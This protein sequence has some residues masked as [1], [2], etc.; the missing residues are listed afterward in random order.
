MRIA[1]V[2]IVHKPLDIRIFQKEC[3][4]LAAAGHEVHLLISDPPS[5]EIDGVRF[6]AIPGLGGVNYFWRALRRLP[7]AYR[8]ARAVDASVYHLHDPHLIPLGLLLKRTGA[9]VV[10]DAH[11]D[12]PRQ[13]VSIYADRPLTGRAHAVVWSV[14]EW[15]AR[16]R[17]DAFVAA[18]PRILERF[19][20]ARSVV[21]HNF[22]LAEEFCHPS[23][24]GARLPQGEREH[25]VVYVGGI[26][27]VRCI[28]EMVDMLELVPAALGARLVLM[29]EFSKERPELEVEVRAKRGWERVEYLGYRSRGEVVEQLAKARIGLVLMYPLPNHVEAM[30]NKMWEY[31]AAGLP[32]IA[33]NFPYWEGILSRAGCGLVVDPKDPREI[34]EAVEH[35]LRYPDEAEAMGRRGREAYEQRYNWAPEGERLVGVYRDLAARLES[36]ARAS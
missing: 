19:P 11:E 4:T 33:S 14:L 21:V 35:L 15:L 10:Y 9:V 7:T 32:I 24:D 18:T 22:P 1:H 34:A 2:S 3:R 31:M 12:S 25:T 27:A 16:R 20:E 36:E 30:P 29:R 5:A 17:F 26:T 28:R 8:R 13:A 23:L 6:H